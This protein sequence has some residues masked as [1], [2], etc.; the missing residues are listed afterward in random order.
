M[1]WKGASVKYLWVEEARMVGEAAVVQPDVERV[2]H[3]GEPLDAR[4]G[5]GEQL[6]PEAG[7]EQQEEDGGV[8]RL[9]RRAV[10]TRSVGVAVMTLRV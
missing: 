4:G 5:V 1:E 10:T 2:G 9:E 7:E 3:D 6:V 8:G